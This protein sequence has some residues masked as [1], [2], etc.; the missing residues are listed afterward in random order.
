MKEKRIGRTRWYW[1]GWTSG[2]AESAK[3][4]LESRVKITMIL[5]GTSQGE[6]GWDIWYRP[7]E[8]WQNI[9]CPACNM[10]VAREKVEA[11]K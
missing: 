2:S 5:A 6:A 8:H 1:Y 10:V 11:A 9:V 7:V 3:A 4:R